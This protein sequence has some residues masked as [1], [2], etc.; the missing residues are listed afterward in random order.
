MT[1]FALLAHLLGFIAPAVAVGLCLWLAAR[2]RPRKS[3][4]STTPHRAL[5]WL[6]LAGV[7]VLLAGLVLLGRDG[8]MA[9]YAALVLVQ[10]G[11]AAW[12]WRG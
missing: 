2:L 5:L 11:L 10:G 3:K 6:V 1:F 12:F 9:T 4:P 7:L 8:K